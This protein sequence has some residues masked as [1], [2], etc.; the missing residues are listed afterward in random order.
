MCNGHSSP[1]RLNHAQSKS[2]PAPLKT[3][4]GDPTPPT[5]ANLLRTVHATWLHREINPRCLS[6]S[7]LHSDIAVAADKHYLVCDHVHSVIPHS[8]PPTETSLKISQSGCRLCRHS[9]L[10]HCVK[11]RCQRCICCSHI[12]E[13]TRKR[14][15]VDFICLFGSLPDCWSVHCARGKRRLSRCTCC[16]QA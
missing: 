7:L 15:S 5:S 4:C 16:R 3:D 1:R 6:L 11:R 10:S 9:R 8:P 12:S 2:K 14:L 13:D